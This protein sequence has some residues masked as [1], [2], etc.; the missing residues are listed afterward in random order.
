MTGVIVAIVAAVLLIVV[1]A[2]I[3][4][5]TIKNVRKEKEDALNML[6]ES[7]DAV[8]S[9]VRE[10]YERTLSE[11]KKSHDEALSQQLATVKAQVTAESEKMLKAREEELE[12][13]ARQTFE[14]ITGGLDKNIKDMKEAFELNRKTHSKPY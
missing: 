2:Y 7:H 13:R 4:A 1:M 6:R 9:G 14:A 3:C 5:M 12:K 8:L 11:L 10:S